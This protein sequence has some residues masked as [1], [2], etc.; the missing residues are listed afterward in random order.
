MKYFVDHTNAD[1]NKNDVS[2]QDTAVKMI[3]TRDIHE[4]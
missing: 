1:E 2:R 3:K 4:N